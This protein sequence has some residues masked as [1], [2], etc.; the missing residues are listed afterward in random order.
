MSELTNQGGNIGDD[1][2][3]QQGE[4]AH[5]GFKKKVQIKKRKMRLRKITAVGRTL[6]EI[7]CSTL[8]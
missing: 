6:S 7:T 4:A 5:D 1:R 2:L 8:M 3:L